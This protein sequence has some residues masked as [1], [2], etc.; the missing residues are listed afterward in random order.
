MNWQNEHVVITGACGF[1][2]SHLAEALVARGAHVKALT[3]YDA[4]G[5]RGWLDDVEA[6]VRN[7]LDIVASDVRDTECMYSLIEQGDVVFHLAALIGIPY[8]YHAPR[9][10]MD[11]NVIGTLNILEAS[12]RA[13]VRSVMVVSTSEVYGT[14]VQV[15]IP[16]THPLQAQSPYSASKIG[17]E[18]IA[19]SFYRSFELPVVIVRPFNTYGPRQSARAVIPTIL[20]QALNGSGEVLL[21]DPTTTRDFNFVQDTVL[22]MIKLAECEE[23]IGKI[24]NVGTR[25]ETAIG[26]VA[27]IVGD[28]VGH[29]I[30]IVHDPERVRPAGSEVRRL[31]AD[32]TLLKSLV[33]WIPPARLEE[34]LRVT[35]DWMK[36]RLDHYQA[37]RYYI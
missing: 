36:D 17:A 23:A 30:K 12:R 22:G 26:R 15:P 3:Y 8:S 19:E 33:D 18:K 11:T 24:I 37:G 5:S 16:E 29:E 1:I 27:E 10:Y 13:G 35:A 21:G 20:M 34:G 2:G 32:N 9:S 25:T 4:R 28:V 6:G 14:A 31:C 7:K